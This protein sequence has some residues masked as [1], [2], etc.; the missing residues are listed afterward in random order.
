MLGVILFIVLLASVASAW[1]LVRHRRSPFPSIDGADIIADIRR[2]TF[3]TFYPD[4][5]ATRWFVF[6]EGGRIVGFRAVVTHIGPDGQFDRLQMDIH[7][8]RGIIGGVWSHSRLSADATEGQYKAGRLRLTDSIAILTN[9]GITLANK[10]IRMTQLIDR[11]AIRVSQVSSAVAPADYLPEGTLWLA[12]RIV[13]EEQ[14]KAGFRLIQDDRII[15]GGG[16]PFVDVSISYAGPGD[17]ADPDV[18]AVVT[19][20]IGQGR[21][22]ENYYYLDADGGLIRQVTGHTTAS[23]VD[24]EQIVSAFPEAPMLL[25]Q[26]MKHAGMAGDNQTDSEEGDPVDPLPQL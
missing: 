25:S 6:H 9:T 1:L 4:S 15:Q 13:A 16:V 24:Q 20:Q 12:C 11:G 5:P 8:S 17:E 22:L 14:V 3:P 19:L 2:L 7:D 10:H 18:A 23:L 26:M 21:T